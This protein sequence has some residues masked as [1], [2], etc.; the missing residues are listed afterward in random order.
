MTLDLRDPAGNLNRHYFQINPFSADFGFP[1]NRQQPLHNTLGVLVGY[2]SSET[3]DSNG[4]LQRRNYRNYVGDDGWNP[5]GLSHRNPRTSFERTEYVTDDLYGLGNPTYTDTYYTDFDGLGHYREVKTEGNFNLGSSTQVGNVRKTKTW[6]NPF[7]SYPNFTPWPV[8]DPWLINIYTL[9]EI[10]ESD[11]NGV[12]QKEL[13][14][15]CF[16][17]QT[18]FLGWQRKFH[19]DAQSSSTDLLTKYVRTTQS[20]GFPASVEYFGGDSGGAIIVGSNDTCSITGLPSPPYKINHTYQ[21]GVLATSQYQGVNF[22][23]LDE[24]IDASTGLVSSSKGIDGVLSTNYQYDALGRLV[25]I[26][27]TQDAWTKIT[28][29]DAVTAAAVPRVDVVSLENGNPSGG[30]VLSESKYVYDGFGRMWSTRRRIPGFSN[31][32]SKETILDALGRTVTSKEEVVNE[33]PGKTNYTFDAFGRAT[34]IVP[35]DGSTHTTNISYK[36]VREI[37]KSI[38]VGTSR[39]AAGNIMETTSTST[40]VYDQHGRLAKVVEA[41]GTETRYLY[42]VGNRLKKVMMTSGTV[43]QTRTLNYDDRGFLLSETHPEKT[44][45]VIY[46]NYDCMGNYRRK[47][48][49]SS[50]LEFIYDPAE[51]LKQVRDRSN[52]S[53]LKEFLYATTNY[54][55]TGT[56]TNFQKGKV[57]AAYRLNYNTESGAPHTTMVQELFEY[58][59]RQ[60][61][62][63]SHT[64]SVY[65]ND[66]LAGRF[67]PTLWE[68]N[69]LGQ[70]ESTLYPQHS[71][72]KVAEPV[73]QTYIYGFLTSIHKGPPSNES[74]VSFTY[75]SNGQINRQTHENGVID[76]NE[77]DPFGRAMSYRIRTE[78]AITNWD[79]GNYSYDGA[80]NVVKTGNSWFVYDKLSRLKEGRV[81]LGT[82]GTGVERY[83]QYTFDAFGNIQSI[84]GWLARVTTTDLNTNRLTAFSSFYDAAGN[85]TSFNGYTF[86]YDAFHQIKKMIAGSDEW[87]YAYTANDERILTYKVGLNQTNKWTVRDLDGRVLKE[88]TQDRSTNAWTTDKKYIYAGSRLVVG[89]TADLNNTIH[90]HLDHLGT[91]RLI[92]QGKQYPQSTPLRSML[93]YHVYF[94]FG[95]EATNPNQDSERM[96]FTGHERDSNNAST[97]MD[98]LD[99]MHA[100]YFSPVAGRFTSADSG[101]DS[102]PSRPQSWNLYAYVRNNPANQ[103]DPTGKFVNAI[104]F[105][106][107]WVNKYPAVL[108][109]L[110]AMNQ[111]LSALNRALQYKQVLQDAAAKH[112][113]PWTLLAAI[114]IRESGFRNVAENATASSSGR[115]R[116]ISNRH[117]CSSRHSANC[118]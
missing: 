101:R 33:T 11:E 63:S 6:Y 50:D 18:G 117:R 106:S 52:N 1:F 110:A 49:G 86:Q 13:T 82:D 112:N 78:N 3:F 80:G 12:E 118:L 97:T 74:Y 26:Q 75:H 5:N 111:N 115:A 70:I 107:F 29:V 65:I 114:G 87:L 96:K 38:L 8:N 67:G 103:T 71:G 98:D 53:L 92:T 61:R 45:A 91:P 79:S 73:H 93:A 55:V 69:E 68:Y 43:T 10:A 72:L 2:L 15:F 24:T 27:P 56:P 108:Q 113:I 66:A 25:W 36:G 62:T 46:Q 37:K 77:R 64:T 44:S 88:F 104:Y 19:N 30:A 102:E 23:S 57:V 17:K 116:S 84:A 48:D 99:Y 32:S 28:Y 42:D 34:K 9:T 41:N 95:E 14:Q 81:R 22:K 60:G 100:R 89:Q 94:P 31:L 20:K 83:Q 59:G 85:Q 109:A 21:H 39:D 47:I 76:V 4:T 105:L 35:P 16:E 58:S 51:R 40:E 54:P 90:Y 7:Y